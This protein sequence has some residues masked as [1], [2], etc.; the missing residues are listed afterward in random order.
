MLCQQGIFNAHYNLKIA[1]QTLLPYQNA[2][3]T[4]A[5]LPPATQSIRSECMLWEHSAVPVYMQLYLMSRVP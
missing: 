4:K 2:D 3:L 1:Y 5:A